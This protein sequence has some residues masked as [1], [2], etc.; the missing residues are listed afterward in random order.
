MKNLSP[1]HPGV[2]SALPAAE[3]TLVELCIA[4]GNM[5]QPLTPTEG[6]QIMNSLIHNR[7]IQEELM[8]FK[9]RH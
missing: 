9:H 2:T 8:E 4:M 6:L 3:E 5:W 7:E 1:S